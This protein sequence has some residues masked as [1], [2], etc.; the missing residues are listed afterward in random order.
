[1]NTEKGD[2]TA[3]RPMH[4]SG[5]YDPFEKTEV[6]EADETKADLG[7]V[8]PGMH[9]NNDD[10]NSNGLRDRFESNAAYEKVPV[11]PLVSTT[12]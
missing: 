12:V 1:M 9:I 6:L 11:V 8:H 7:P 5:G 2:L 10:D 4:S 3:Y